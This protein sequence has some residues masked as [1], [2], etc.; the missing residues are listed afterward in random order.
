[1]VLVRMVL[2]KKRGAGRLLGVVVKI[3][4]MDSSSGIFVG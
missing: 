4:S 1:M 3:T 2:K